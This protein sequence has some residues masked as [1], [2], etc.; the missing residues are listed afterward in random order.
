MC[1]SQKCQLSR[2]LVLNRSSKALLGSSA[3]IWGI[4]PQTSMECCVL[5][6]R[7]QMCISSRFIGKGR[8]PLTQARSRWVAACMQRTYSGLPFDL[9][10]HGD[11]GTEMKVVGPSSA[12]LRTALLLHPNTQYI[13]VKCCCRLQIWME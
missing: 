4:D 13:N 5:L 9:H 6:T 8:S 7:P 10:S 1:E 11:R 3:R 12:S 2:L